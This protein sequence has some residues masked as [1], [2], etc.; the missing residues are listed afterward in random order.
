VAGA[1]ALHAASLAVAWS[2]AARTWSTAARI[3]LPCPVP[4]AHEPDSTIEV[5]WTGSPQDTPPDATLPPGSSAD[6]RV[7]RASQLEPRSRGSRDL[8]PGDANDAGR[9]SAGDGL[10][11]TPDGVP[12]SREGLPSARDGSGAES[13]SSSSSGTWSLNPARSGALPSR[14]P[15]ADLGV[16]S[17]LS[18]RLAPQ[19][20]SRKDP[21]VERGEATAGGLRDAL[22]QHD[23][24]LGL[25]RGGAI[26]SELQA[27]AHGDSAPVTGKAIFEVTVGSNGS[28]WV[29]V[30]RSDGAT[31]AWNRVASE[32]AAGLRSK[33]LR[34]PPGA[35]AMR[36]ALEVDAR[37]VEY[38]G[39]KSR[40]TRLEA[41]PGKI[42]S[43]GMY[44][45][46]PGLYLGGAG[47][48]CAYELGLVPVP[49]QPLSAG[50]WCDPTKLVVKPQR[51]VS[52]RVVDEGRL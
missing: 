47:R 1:L 30:S 39:S 50:G 46:L 14:P 13:L 22:D 48:V 23:R 52:V 41:S 31:P 15:A 3:E 43:N 8:P 9:P 42:G 45:K 24:E 21:G 5:D 4:Q 2:T 36:F 11:S 25:G 7:A 20:A 40:P 38:D 44:E 51:L 17:A 18:W 32:L 16:G 34:I 29:G 12:S 10:P 26:V 35:R 49:M 6:P 27:A 28:V 19:L 37:V 33:H